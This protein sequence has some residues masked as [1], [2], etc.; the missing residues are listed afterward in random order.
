MITVLVLLGVSRCCGTRMRV[1]VYITGIYRYA[2]YYVELCTY[3]FKLLFL[4]FIKQKSSY[5]C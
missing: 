3:M 5:Y 1:C 4:N 2:T